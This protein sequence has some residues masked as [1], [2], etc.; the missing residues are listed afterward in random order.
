MISCSI[1]SKSRSLNSQDLLSC[2]GNIS[3]CI[4]LAQ[5]SIISFILLKLIATH[6][7]LR[8]LF[9]ISVS[10]W[11]LYCLSFLLGFIEC[12]LSEPTG[13]HQCFGEVGQPLT[14]NLP[15]TT[16]REVHFT[17]D[18]G[19]KMF[20]IKN[21]KSITYNESVVFTNQTF[22]FNKATKWHSGN[23]IMEEFGLNGKQLK[24]VKVHVEIRGME[25]YVCETESLFITNCT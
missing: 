17:K 2:T 21:N 6:K 8:M 3:I 16:N 19:Y 18:N 11:E 15:N 1:W 12:N 24:E 5:L 22:K 23:Y 9:V 20:K 7:W 10:Y 25:N 4:K 14:F 13:A